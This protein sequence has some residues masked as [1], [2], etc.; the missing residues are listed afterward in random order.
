MSKPIALIIEDD[1]KLT[2]IFSQALKMAGFETE[3]AHD[4]AIAL[5]R[6][7]EIVPDLIL[8]DL[9][10]PSV[11]GDEILRQIRADARMENVHV[12]LATADQLRAELLRD[13]VTLVLLKPISVVQL[14]K[15]ASRIISQPN[16]QS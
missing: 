10:L 3:F 11:P 4:G 1:E 7:N 8:L 16:S 9:H 12:V 13:D 5:Q 6:L 14:Q 15:L 2:E